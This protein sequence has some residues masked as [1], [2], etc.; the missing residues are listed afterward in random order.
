[1]IFWREATLHLKGN[2]S[3][4]ASVAPGRDLLHRESPGGLPMLSAPCQKWIHS[5]RV[6]VFVVVCV[7]G[8]LPFSLWCKANR[9]TLM[10]FVLG[11]PLSMLQ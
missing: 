5:M 3:G 2:S 4:L 10:Y 7:F 9:K 8:R 11:G 6:F 1:M